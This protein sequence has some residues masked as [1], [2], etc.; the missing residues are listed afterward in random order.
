MLILAKEKF[1]MKEKTFDYKS[2][3]VTQIMDETFLNEERGV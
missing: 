2:R 3:D 1:Q